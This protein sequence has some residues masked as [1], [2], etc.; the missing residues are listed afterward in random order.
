MPEPETCGNCGQL[1]IPALARRK[2]DGTDEP[3]CTVCATRW[4]LSDE[5]WP[6]KSSKERVKDPCL[7]TCKVAT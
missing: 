4:L 3:L 1:C 7:N 6:S 5:E 2:P